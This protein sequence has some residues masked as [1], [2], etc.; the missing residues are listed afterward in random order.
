MAGLLGASSARFEAVTTDTHKKTC[1]HFSNWHIFIERC[2]L[3]SDPYLDGFNASDKIK[4][5]GAYMHAVREQTYAPSTKGY[6]NLVASSC[7]A[8]LDSVQA[9]FRTSGRPDPALDPDGKTSVFLHYQLRGYANND[10]STKPQKPIPLCLIKQMISRGCSDP[11]LMAFHELVRLAFFF[12]MRSCEYL[13]T[14]GNG[15]PTRSAFETWFS[16]KTTALSRTA[17]RT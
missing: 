1:R 12:A 2:E 6:D 15:E 17:T 3:G 10:P 13:V 8:A 16:V 7:R 14:T 4:M 9:A 11:G 5:L